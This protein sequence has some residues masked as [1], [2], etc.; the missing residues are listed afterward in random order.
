MKTT[1]KKQTEILAES[2]EETQLKAREK[3]L[4]KKSS[5]KLNTKKTKIEKSPV[6]SAVVPLKKSQWNPFL[7]LVRLVRN[8]LKRL[9]RMTIGGKKEKAYFLEYLA[10][11]ITSGMDPASAMQSIG[12][13]LRTRWI[14]QLVVEAEERIQSGSSVWQTLQEAHFLP[15]HVISLL[16]IGEESGRLSDNLKA[17]V[18]QQQKDA[19][20]KSKVQSAMMYP[21]FVMSITLIVGTGIAWF[22]L[23]QLALVFS[24]LEMD[25][26]FITRLLIIVGDYLRLHGTVAVPVFFAVFLTLIYVIFGMPKTKVIGQWFLLH[27]PGVKMVVQQVELSRTGFILGTLL[28]AGLPIIEAVESLRQATVMYHYRRF[29]RVLGVALEGGDSFA[30][31]FSSFRRMG[32]LIPNPIQQMIETAERSGTLPETLMQIGTIYGE[33]TDNSTKNLSVILEPILLLIVWLGV[34]GV[35]LAVILPI[36]S[37]IGNLTTAT[38]GG[39]ATTETETSSPLNTA[40]QGDQ[41]VEGFVGKVTGG[42]QDIVQ[43][44]GEYLGIYSVEKPMAEEGLVVHRLRILSPIGYVNVRSSPSTAAMLLTQAL[45]ASDY[46]WTVH[47]NGWYQIILSDGSFGWI[48]DT[49]AEEIIPVP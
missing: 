27:L 34:V 35:A 1:P 13:D 8:S 3:T 17:V 30:Q 19:E 45:D 4:A 12:K 9:D 36:Y 7:A 16:R 23:P 24:S 15:S 28:Q 33:K 21:V 5:K 26:P 41:A 20:F 43:S 29:Y 18:L 37:L 10:V 11:L 14:R 40:L 25:L 47:E 2:R 48:A 22:I 31:V 39:G 38:S 44:A 42:I 32:R 46:E 49:Y 6:A